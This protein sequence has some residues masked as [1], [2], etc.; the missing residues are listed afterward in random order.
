MEGECSRWVRGKEV[1]KEKTYRFQL[2][3]NIQEDIRFLSLEYCL[4]NDYSSFFN[5]LAKRNLLGL[6]IVVMGSC[7]PD[8]VRNINDI[9][10]QLQLKCIIITNILNFIVPINLEKCQE[11]IYLKMNSFKKLRNTDFW[12]KTMKSIAKLPKL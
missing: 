12:T 2:P 4:S 10:D 11:L 9:L 6:K 5:S 3:T 7:D 1:Q 8:L